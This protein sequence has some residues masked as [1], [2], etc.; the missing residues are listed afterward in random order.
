M[1]DKSIGFFI[2][3]SAVT[4]VVAEPIHEAGVLSL[5]KLMNSGELTAAQLTQHHL[6]RIQRLEP[7]LNAIISLNPD[8]L[9][10]ARHSDVLRKR[11]EIKGPLHGI[12][13]LLKDN[14]ETTGAVATTA[15][16]LA[17]KH[18][19]TNRDASLVKNLKAAGAIILGKTNLSEWA[20]FR[21]ERSSSGWS[22]IGG[23]TN[24]PYDFA[25]NP[26]GSSA[27][28][29]VAAAAGLATLTVGT[30]TNGSIV[31]P[32]SANG[33]VGLK[34]T[35]GLV[36]RTGVVPLAHSQDTAGPIT[37]SVSDAAMLLTAMQGHDVN[38]AI[39]L[40]ARA[41]QQRDY[42][43]ALQIDGINGKRIGI[44]R[45]SK[46]FHSEVN[47]HFELAIKEFEAAGAT[48]VD[49]L[50]WQPPKGFWDASYEVLLFEFKHDLNQYLAN[51]PNALSN[52][53][54]IN[55]IADNVNNKAVSMPWFEQEILVKAQAKSD[56]SSD[57]Y[58]AALD[59]VQQATRANGLDALINE[60]QLDAIIAPTGDPAWTT[61]LIN[62]DHF[63]GSSSSLAAISGYPNI[64]V[65]MGNVHGLP[66]GL[67]IFS[68]AYQEP[69]LIAIAY[70]YE[71]R[72]QHRK[73][74]LD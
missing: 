39:T 69:T 7:K 47:Q 44:L 31:C 66:V 10:D 1:T 13:V 60:H 33:V 68:K 41:H 67:S 65:P 42:S 43:K 20:N 72:T 35:L 55:I 21:S 74:P 54:L 36:S 73:P 22:A 37:R 18:N 52:L 3:L 19:I 51:L 63:G 40:D 46:G 58:K 26:C 5:Q 30:E 4:A 32:A 50:S 48:M 61:D 64:T 6:E 59:L 56:L 14:I 34:P 17:L 24:N 9:K 15:G 2:L 57:E 16:A 62:G 28:S 70:A 38:D 25:R 53:T 45:S 49:D 71:Q 27:G 23:Q 29:A 11:G 8:A 12:P